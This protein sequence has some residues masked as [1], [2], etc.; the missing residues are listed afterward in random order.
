MEAQTI[1]EEFIAN[2]VSNIVFNTKQ[3]LDLTT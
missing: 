1:N 2:F 3:I